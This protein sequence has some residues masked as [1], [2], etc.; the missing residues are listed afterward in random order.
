MR[1]PLTNAEFLDVIK[2]MIEY[3]TVYNKTHPYNA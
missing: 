1:T 3:N 2:N